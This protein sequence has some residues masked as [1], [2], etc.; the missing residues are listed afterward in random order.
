MKY[1]V[2]HIP[3]PTEPSLSAGKEGGGDVPPDALAHDGS[4]RE[5][6]LHA[7]R[8]DHPSQLRIR[9]RVCVHVM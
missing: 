7:E 1:I 3:H 6:T 2:T 5:E 9:V 8:S 4:A